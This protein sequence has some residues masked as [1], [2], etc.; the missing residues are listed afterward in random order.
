MRKTNSGS[1][2]SLHCYINLS[3]ASRFDISERDV[4]FPSWNEK[5][6]GDLLKLHWIKFDNNTGTLLL[7]SAHF[8]L[9]F[10]GA[11]DAQHDP[12]YSYSAPGTRIYINQPFDPFLQFFFNPKNSYF[13]FHSYNILLLSLLFLFLIKRTKAL[14]FFEEYSI[15]KFSF[16]I[17]NVV[18][19]ILRFAKCQSFRGKI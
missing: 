4:W 11:N 8:Y 5:K 15:T 14:I 7:F 13:R 18:E 2:I 6:L 10:V 19:N 3:F 9:C 12:S 16:I 17:E 1:K